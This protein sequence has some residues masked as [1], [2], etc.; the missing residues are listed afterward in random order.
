MQFYWLVLAGLATWRLTHLLCAEDGPW[1]LLVRLRRAAGNGF[2]GKLLDCFQCLSL[3]F[4]A[5][6]AYFIGATWLERVL[7][8]LAA[9]AFACLLELMTTG[10]PPA[11]PL[12][13]YV[14]DKEV[15]DELLRAKQT[16]S[17]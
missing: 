12:A 2:W 11:P 15:E 6:L 14:E 3:W 4:A 17:P 8:W 16:K 10:R 1:N 7:L 13:S 9:S 5:P